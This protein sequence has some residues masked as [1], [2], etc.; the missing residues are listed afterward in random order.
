M[1]NVHRFPCRRA[2][3]LTIGVAAAMTFAGAPC[4]AHATPPTTVNVEI[5]WMA[6]AAHSHRPSTTEMNAVVQMF[7]CHGI[8]LNYVIDDS[9]LEINK[10][11]DDTLPNDFFTA[12]GPGRFATIKAAKF[13]HAGQGGWHYCIFGHNYTADGSDTTSSGLADTE[14]DDFVVTLG[15]FAGR[16]GTPFDRAATFAHELGHN[17]GLSHAGSQSEALVGPRKPNYAS[18]MSYQYQLRGVRSHMSCLD[19][20]DSTS[21][22]KE[23]DYSNG[24][25]PSINENALNEALGV[26]IRS[27]DWNCNG[28]YGGVVIQ[29]TDSVPWCNKNGGKQV[30]SDYNDWQNISDVT[31]GAYT[32]PDR[33]LEPCIT[34]REIEAIR[35][36]NPSVCTGGPVSVS[37]EACI[38]GMMVWVDASNGGPQDGTGDSPFNTFMQAYIVATNGSVLYLQPG[39]LNTGGA[40]V[41][42]NKPLTLAGPGGV[43]ITP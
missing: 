23:L 28:T 8:V 41:L 35:E 21:L 37:S 38:N 16:I 9:L 43:T 12:T 2:L 36:K 15:S 5:D 30:L 25:L 19:L 14:R 29:D 13:D 6:D 32:P 7:A 33:T 17:L 42:L 39:S 4:P 3:G 22:F 10:M 40:P 31:F 27:V 11:V 18:I 1:T 20:S 24:R 34:S 26:G